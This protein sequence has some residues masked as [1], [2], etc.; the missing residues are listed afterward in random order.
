MSVAVEPA[1]LL[2]LA[3]AYRAFCEEHPSL[4]LLTNHAPPV[5]AALFV[6]LF[7][8]AAFNGVRIAAATVLGTARFNYGLRHESC[9][10]PARL[11]RHAQA[12]GLDGRLTY[13]P[14]SGLTALCYGFVRPRVAISAGLLA[15]LDDEQLMA[16]LAHEREHLRRRD[17]TLYLVLR[18]LAAAAYMFPL[19]AAL[20]RRLEAGIEL[21]A[22]R[23]AIAAV[24]REALASALLATLVAPR[25]SP[26]GTV[27]LS[28]T[29]ARI[30]YLTGAPA[31]PTIPAATIAASAGLGA[32]IALAAV[33]MAATVDVMRMV[34]EFCAGLR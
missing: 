23:A 1:P 2:P 16:V 33:Y 30:A 18:V 6:S 26:M 19:A 11:A 9:I 22:D 28:A 7:A 12:F 29:E 32:L 5:V 13:L 3:D 17:P 31:L 27:G 21:N 4:A 14:Q 24:G 34:C 20:R 8:V 15:S 10:P 25:S